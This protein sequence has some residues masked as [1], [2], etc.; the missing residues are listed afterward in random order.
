MSRARAA[1]GLVVWSAASACAPEAPHDDFP[2]MRV[3]GQ[4]IDWSVLR[5]AGIEGTDAFAAATD[6]DNTNVTCALIALRAFE[7]PCAVA[8][9]Y[10]PRRAEVF[11][12]LGV[13]T[14]CPTS[15]T[16]LMMIEAV[17]TCPSTPGTA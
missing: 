10:D 16:T 14:V 11:A 7:V 9:V 1:L 5:K 3:V 13:R 17:L 2:G 15:K 6:G 4:A 8:R 12:R